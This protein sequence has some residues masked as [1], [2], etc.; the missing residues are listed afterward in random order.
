MSSTLLG[1]RR[2][3]LASN[4]TWRQFLP[5]SYH[6][7]DTKFRLL[8]DPAAPSEQSSA[9]VDDASS[10]VGG[11]GD[12]TIMIAWYC[13]IGVSAL[14]LSV[15]LF[16]VL[17]RCYYNRVQYPAIRARRAAQEAS[18]QA[19]LARMQANVSKFTAHEN[20]QRTRDLCALL[21]PQTTEVG[22]IF[23]LFG[24]AMNDFRGLAR[25]GNKNV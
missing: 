23:I 8:I 12:T 20:T 11:D 7:D 1:E 22:I 6:D 3:L 15:S 25:R 16:T 18:R 19:A 21:L 24:A 4:L 5:S 17:Y 2:T 10:G 13:F 14:V 9:A